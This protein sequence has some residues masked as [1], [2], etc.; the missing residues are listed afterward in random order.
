MYNLER[1]RASAITA[2]AYAEREASK[3]GPPGLYRDKG[4]T[5]PG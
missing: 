2:K 5:P 3:N 4:K 1:K